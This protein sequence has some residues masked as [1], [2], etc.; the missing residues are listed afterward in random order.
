MQN[1]YTN[2]NGPIV[3]APRPNRM[4]GIRVAAFVICLTIGFF[5]SNHTPSMEVSIRVEGVPNSQVSN[6]SQG[7]TALELTLDKYTVVSTYYP[8]WNATYI[9]CINSICETDT[10][11]WTLWQEI[12]GV[13]TASEVG[14]DLFV[15]IAGAQMV[16]LLTGVDDAPEH[17]QAIA[18]A[19]LEAVKE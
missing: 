17:P 14:A 16:W 13:L 3:F 19:V 2:S 5:V 10:E 15:L 8:E 18:A 12:D 7:Q 4:F 9:N 6:I 1:S 11:W